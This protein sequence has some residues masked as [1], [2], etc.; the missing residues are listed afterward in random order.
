MDRVPEIWVLA[1]EKWV[2]RQDE[3]GF[4]FIFY[5]IFRIFHDFFKVEYAEGAAAKL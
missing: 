4:F 1:M 2:F 3:Q 5:Q